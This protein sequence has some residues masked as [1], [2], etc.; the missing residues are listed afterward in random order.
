MVIVAGAAVLLNG[1]VHIAH[2][3]RA[4]LPHTVATGVLNEFLAVTGLFITVWAR[5]ILGGNWSARI[6]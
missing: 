2:W 5:L 1:S 6:T 3:N 4:V